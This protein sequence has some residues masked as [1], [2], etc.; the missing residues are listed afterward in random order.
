MHDECVGPDLRTHPVRTVEITGHIQHPWAQIVNPLRSF[1]Q[2]PHNRIHGYR[3]ARS[4]DAQNGESVAGVGRRQPVNCRISRG[5]S[6]HRRMISAARTKRTRPRPERYPQARSLSMDSTDGRESV[7]CATQ[8]LDIGVGVDNLRRRGHR[9][10]DRVPHAVQAMH[11]TMNGDKVGKPVVNRIRAPARTKSSGPL[12]TDDT[13]VTPATLSGFTRSSNLRIARRTKKAGAPTRTAARPR[14]PGRAWPPDAA[15]RPRPGDQHHPLPGSS[16]S[17]CR[18]MPTLPKLLRTPGRGDL[19]TVSSAVRRGAD[20][21]SS[22]SANEAAVKRDDGDT[23]FSGQRPTVEHDH[24]HRPL[25]AGRPVDL[26]ERN[27]SRPVVHGPSPRSLPILV[28]RPQTQPDG[29]HRRHRQTH[30][31]SSGQPPA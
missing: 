18:S 27:R 23:V 30:H 24:P 15:P 10:R 2:L 22:S 5:H 1:I 12:F 21:S 8:H 14:R 25:R 13:T 4:I 6:L 11:E 3:G 28:E 19:P 16:I 29:S 31:S 26:G 20:S 9:H 7:Q 17:G